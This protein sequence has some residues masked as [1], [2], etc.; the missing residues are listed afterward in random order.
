MLHTASGLKLACLT[1]AE[2]SQFC[3]SAFS[4]TVCIFSYCG[5]VGGGGELTEHVYYDGISKLF[6]DII[7][8]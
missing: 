2:K 4:V 1:W 5:C 6:M 3:V 8:L 7:N